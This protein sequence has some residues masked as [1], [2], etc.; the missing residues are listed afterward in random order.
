MSGEWR[1]VKRFDAF[2]VS[3]VIEA[4]RQANVIEPCT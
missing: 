2:G 3:L 4:A 1:V